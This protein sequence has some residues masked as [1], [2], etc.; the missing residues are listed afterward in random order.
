MVAA[1]SKQP[2]RIEIS[3]GNWTVM[4]TGVRG[5]SILVQNKFPA[6]AKATMLESMAATSDKKKSKKDRTPRD[7]DEEFGASTHV[8]TEG[9][10]GVC[11]IAFKSAMVDACRFTNVPMTKAKQLMN[12]I[13]DGFDAEDGTPLVRI[14]ANDPE[15]R[16][17]AVR[18]DNGST[19]IRTRAMFRVWEC[20]VQIEFDADQIHA[21]SI[22]NLLSRAG[23][24]VGIGEGRPFSK[25]SCGQGWGTFRLVGG[26]Q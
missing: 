19:D 17:D 4:T 8:S 22:A 16:Q 5:T 12:V 26:V 6:K 2:E 11:A 20:K 21:S 25:N 1:T 15:R 13:P 18:N 9:W 3:A 23:R 24:Q 10:H 7:Y 14:F